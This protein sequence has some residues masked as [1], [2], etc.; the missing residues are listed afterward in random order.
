MWY[1]GVVIKCAQ[2]GRTIGFPTINLDPTIVAKIKEGIYAAKVKHN[3][4]I[5]LGALYFG[6]RLVKQET[7]NVLEI[8]LLEFDKEVYDETIQF[9]LGK[10]IRGIQNFA[11]MDEMKIQI[12]QDIKDVKAAFSS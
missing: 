7:H 9:Q 1:E 2:D 4:K 12:K 10:Y 6:P 5:Y 8:F 11:S 3:E